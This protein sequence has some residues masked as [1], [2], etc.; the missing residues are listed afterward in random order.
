MEEFVE[1]ILVLI[2]EHSLILIIQE[3]RVMNFQPK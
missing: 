2:V 1:V 3:F